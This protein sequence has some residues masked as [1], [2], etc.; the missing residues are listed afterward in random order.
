MNHIIDLNPVGDD[1]YFYGVETL[2]RESEIAWFGTKAEAMYDAETT[3]GK[4]MPIELVR[5]RKSEVERS[6]I[7]YDLWG[8][9]IGWARR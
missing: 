1:H 9:D 7:L 4:Y 6:G 5:M 8:N 2:G 3:D